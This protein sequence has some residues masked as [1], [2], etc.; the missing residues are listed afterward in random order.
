MINSILSTK[1]KD[2]AKR[3]RKEAS[4]QL[5]RMRT[6]NIIQEI[7]EKEDQDSID[8]DQEHHEAQGTAHPE[9]EAKLDPIEAQEKEV[10]QTLP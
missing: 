10:R 7:Q 9:G 5:K 4:L 3:D 1:D 6:N 2:G 8:W